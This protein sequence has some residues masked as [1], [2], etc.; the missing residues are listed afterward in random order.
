MCWFGSLM[1]RGGRQSLGRTLVA[2]IELKS[3][4]ANK[5]HQ[6]GPFHHCEGTYRRRK[7]YGNM[8]TEEEKVAQSVSYKNEVR[9]DEVIKVQL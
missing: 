3:K 8:K 2:L 6:N 4:T 9:R 7:A 5:E 1:M